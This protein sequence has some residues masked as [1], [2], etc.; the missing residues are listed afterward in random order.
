MTYGVYLGGSADDYG[1]GIAMDTSG[2]AY[3][4]GETGSHDFPAES[5]GNFPG[6]FAAFVVK[7]NTTG[8][9]LYSTV[10]GGRVAGVGDGGIERRGGHE[11]QRLRHG[12]HRGGFPVTDGNDVWRRP[13]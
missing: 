6:N 4:T 7:L 13:R 10:L 8:T 11:R 1:N 5:G 12:H 9:R 3:V 2:N